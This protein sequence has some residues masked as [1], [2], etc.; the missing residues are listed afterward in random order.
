M[1]KSQIYF[2]TLVEDRTVSSVF[3]VQPCRELLLW[4]NS[5]IAVQAVHTERKCS[6]RKG[7]GGGLTSCV[8]VCVFFFFF[9]L[10]AA[11]ITLALCFANF[12]ASSH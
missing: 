5:Y 6:L 2:I 11:F 3:N 9:N 4:K 12:E 1:V 8:C 7:A 10:V